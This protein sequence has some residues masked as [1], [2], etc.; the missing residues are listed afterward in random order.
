MKRLTTLC[1]VLA[2]SSTTVWA[3]ITLPGTAEIKLDNGLTVQVVERHQLP[4]FSLQLTFHAGSI[5]DPVGKEGLASLASDMLM[6]GTDTR[7]AKQIAD[8]VAFGGGTL[9]NYCGRVSAG[10]SGEFLTAQAENAFEI[11]ADMLLNATMTEAEFEK[12]KT[13]TLGGL[14]SRKE[15]ARSIAGDAIFEAILGESRYAHYAGGEAKTVEALTR[16]DITGY[17]KNYYTPDNCILVVCGD[18]SK[19]SLATWIEKY[20]G[21]WQG[22]AEVNSSTSEFPQVT[23][24]EVI[25]Y[26]KADATQTQIRIG[27][28]GLS[29][30]HADQSQLEVARTVYG[31]S[32]TSRLMNE[33]RVNRGLSYGASCRTSRYVP[34][35]LVYV[36]TFTKNET[37]GEV[38]DIILE[39][40][41]KMQTVI[42]PDS[43]HVGAINYLC[44]TYPG[45]F[46]TNDNIAGVFS[47]IWLNSI[48]K[49]YY[50]D[51]QER[52]REVSAEQ[53]M[54]MAGKYFP[55]DNYKLVLV[56]NAD[57]I[58]EQVAKYGPVT[59]IPLSE[60]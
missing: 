1:L 32:F 23:G 31:G 30:G 17:V 13:R 40:S 2:L 22:T 3:K 43:E 36:S 46:E 16:D 15:N 7:T 45:D 24:K 58:K 6:R 57:E 18:I 47:N 52:L 33:I 41:N 27:G 4:L 60:E 53:A 21:S 48:D 10:F 26:D 11:L 49:S 19:E 29:L 28:N 51:Y 12:T 14:N 59:V 37:V 35:G 38:I 39:E 55:M 42:V 20:F 9:S 5:H 50:E 44:G 8:E 25:I 54:A 56:G 34:G